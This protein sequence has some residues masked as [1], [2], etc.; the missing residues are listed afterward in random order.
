MPVLNPSTY[1][2]IVPRAKASCL[3]YF[4]VYVP[5]DFTMLLGIDVLH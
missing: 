2:E 1:Y 3:N 4:E 5:F